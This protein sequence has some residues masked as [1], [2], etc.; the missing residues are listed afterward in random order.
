MP[1]VIFTAD[2]MLDLKVLRER[3][4]HKSA[5]APARAAKIIAAKI[6]QLRLNP[7]LGRTVVLPDGT[8]A[9]EVTFNL[10]DEEYAAIYRQVDNTLAVLLIRRTDEVGYSA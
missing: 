3:Q 9:L 7:K 8:Y 6:T 4:S 2:A 10:I 1:Q 5:Q